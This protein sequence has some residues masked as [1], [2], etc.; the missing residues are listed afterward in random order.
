MKRIVILL[1]RFYQYVISPWLGPNCRY[2]P[3]CSAYTI[4]AL[5]IHGFWR[6]GAMAVRRIGSCHPWGGSGYDPVMQ[7][8]DEKSSQSSNKAL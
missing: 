7:K 4:E 3:T 2:R 5:K 6:G 1:V 8:N